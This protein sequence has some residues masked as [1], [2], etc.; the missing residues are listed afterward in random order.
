LFFLFQGIEKAHT[1]FFGSLEK[2][3]H[4]PRNG[5]CF[6]N[7]L[8]K[9]NQTSK[10]RKSLFGTLEKENQTSSAFLVLWKGKSYSFII[11]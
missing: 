9:E 3:N 2:E 11:A 4:T 10:D 1:F 8:E 7:T 6:F 5:K